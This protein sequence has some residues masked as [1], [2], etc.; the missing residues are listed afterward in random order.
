MLAVRRPAPGRRSR[1]PTACEIVA[2]PPL[3]VGAGGRL[4]EPRPPLHRR[5]GVGA[6]AGSGSSPPSARC[7][8]RVVLVELFPFGRAKFARELVPLLEAARA[9]GASRRAACATS[10]SAGARTSRRTTTAPAAL[11]DA[12]LDARARAQRPALRAARGDVRAERAAARPGPLH[13]LRRPRRRRRRRAARR[14]SSCPPAAASS[15]SACSA[16]PRRRSRGPARRCALIAG[17]LLPDAAWDRAARRSRARHRARA[18]GARPRR[19]AA[20]RRRVGQ[21][22][23]Y[24]TALEVVARRRPALVVPYA[25]PEEDEQL[26][27]ARR[28]ERLGSCACSRPERLAPRRSRARSRAARSS[29]RAPAASM[30]AA[31]GATAGSSTRSSGPTSRVA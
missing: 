14:T 30:S 11:A 28:L 9:A 12:H 10:S 13:R 6:R 8:P 19:R 27:R 17:P 5:R 20:R 15:A 21:P 24:N 29:R 1:R 4:R 22:G 23:G 7:G 2:L 25:T 3:G 26:R 16:P 31:R 18:V